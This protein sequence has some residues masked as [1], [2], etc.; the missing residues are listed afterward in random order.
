MRN[1]RDRTEIGEKRERPQDLDIGLGDHVDD[2][3]DRELT[4][5][6]IEHR[7]L[8]LGGFLST[9]PGR[10]GL[11]ANLGVQREQI[12]IQRLEFIEVAG[13]LRGRSRRAVAPPPRRADR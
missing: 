11:E 10:R 9:G 4:S 13:P 1:D 2:A 5:R 3:P 8:H 7:A 6:E 12:E